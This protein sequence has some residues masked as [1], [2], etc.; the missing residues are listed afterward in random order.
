MITRYRRRSWG[1]TLAEVAVC[2]G[3]LSSLGGGGNAAW[4]ALGTAR[5]TE[6]ISNLRQVYQAM[7]VQFEEGQLPEAAFYPDVRRDPNAVRTDPRSIVNQIPGLPGSF[8]ISPGAPE[9]FARLG[10]TYV[11]NSGVNGRLIDQLDP[12]TWL[13]MDMNGAAYFTPGITP[14]AQ[15]YLVLYADG[16]VK[17][18][19]QP[20][21]VMRPEDAAQVEAAAQG[22]APLPG[23]PT[24]GG[25][26]AGGP[27]GAPGGPMVTAGG[28]P[29]VKVPTD[30]EA[31]IR[32]KERAAR[33][34]NP[35][36][37]DALDE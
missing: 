8:W 7:L 5:R 37:D 3:I 13:L 2:C 32:Q 14:R 10:L 11:W 22:G 18:E 36:E 19:M 25:P 30:P 23:G 15:G 33:R 4:V 27:A 21:A 29:P 20:P 9:Q 17:Y 31:A 28:P 12:R 16:Q 1:Q 26:T 24:P 34:N 6:A 35:D